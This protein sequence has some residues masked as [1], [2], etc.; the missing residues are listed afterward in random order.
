MTYSSGTR[1]GRNVDAFGDP[2]FAVSAPDVLRAKITQPIEVAPAVGA[3]VVASV[4]ELATA[5]EA[6]LPA[7][8]MSA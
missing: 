1:L 4:L 6:A 2:S 8:Q 3:S 7:D 5:Q